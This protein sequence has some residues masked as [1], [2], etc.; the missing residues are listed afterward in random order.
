MGQRS[1]ANYQLITATQFEPSEWRTLHVCS[2]SPLWWPS[3]VAP[4]PPPCLCL[5]PCLSPC[6]SQAAS[7]G[8]WATVVSTVDTG[9]AWGW[10]TRSSDRHPQQPKRKYKQLGAIS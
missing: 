2:L 7:S 1:A 9:S 3:L 4:L 5:S 8:V 10:D 6:L